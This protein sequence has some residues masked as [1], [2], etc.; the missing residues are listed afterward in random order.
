MLSHWWHEVGPVIAC[1]ARV[2][3]DQRM[4]IEAVSWVLVLQL[5]LPVP[6]ETNAC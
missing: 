1:M 2:G 5:S 4:M 6:L 3:M